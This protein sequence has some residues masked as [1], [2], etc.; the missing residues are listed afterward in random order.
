MPERIIYSEDHVIHNPPFEI[1]D[2]EK[3]PYAEKPD[4]WM[5]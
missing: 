1:Y 5:Q 2:G 3:E 4:P